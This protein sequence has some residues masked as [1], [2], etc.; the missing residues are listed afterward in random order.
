M[1][2]R[3][4]RR[5]AQAVEFALIAPVLFMITGGIVEYGWAFTKYLEAISE[6]RV[7]ARKGSTMVDT[8]T[9]C[10]TTRANVTSRLN[11]SGWFGTVN[12]SVVSVTITTV[13]SVKYMTVDARPAYDRLWLP[14]SLAPSQ[15][16]VVATVR[17]ETQGTTVTNCSA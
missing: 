13:N 5:G 6:V 15:L 1:L 10:T 11:G 7:E 4:R 3:M 8:G 2:Q 17:M 12:N 14:S 9:P 16:H